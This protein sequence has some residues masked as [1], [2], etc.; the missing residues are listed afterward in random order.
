MSIDFYGLN[1]H[2]AV[3][4]DI[5]I[6]R[7]DPG[8]LDQVVLSVRWPDGKVDKLLF[9]DC[10]KLEMMMNFGIIAE[11]SILDFEIFDDSPDI[12]EIKEKWKESGYD[13]KNLRCFQLEMNSTASV[14][15]IYF[16]KSWM[17]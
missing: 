15:K 16:N 2:D 6:D 12:L 4:F 9:D 1:W 13:F 5:H 3:L 8:N 11:E 7:R 14:I 17:V 10:Y